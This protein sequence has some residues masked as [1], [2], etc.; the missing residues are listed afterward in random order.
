M[1]Y[2]SPANSPIIHSRLAHSRLAPKMQ[3]RKIIVKQ[4]HSSPILAIPHSTRSLHDMQK[5]VF[6]IVT[7]GQTDK[8]TD[9]QTDITTL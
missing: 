8:L 9:R 4:C 3:I 6:V 2:P 7:N 5:G 1:G